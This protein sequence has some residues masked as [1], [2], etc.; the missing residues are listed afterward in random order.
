MKCGNWVLYKARKRKRKGGDV[1]VNVPVQHV[2]WEMMERPECRAAIRIPDDKVKTDGSVEDGCWTICDGDVMVDGLGADYDSTQIEVSYKCS[3]CG[4]MCFPELPST[5]EGVKMLVQSRL[6]LLSVD[7]RDRLREAVR[8]SNKKMREDMDRMQ[9][10]MGARNA[11]R[12]KARAEKK[13][14]KHE[15]QAN[16]V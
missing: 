3:K 8:L 12:A 16:Q 15:G 10:E 2:T 13:A 11:A 7:A 6:D 5:E 4:S 9:A 1:F 14:R